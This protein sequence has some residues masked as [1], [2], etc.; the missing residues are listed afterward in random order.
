[1]RLA[2]VRDVAACP[3]STP[4]ASPHSTSLTKSRSFDAAIR[5]VLTRPEVL[6]TKTRAT[7]KTKSSQ[8]NVDNT[9]SI[10]IQFLRTY[11]NI[12][13]FLFRTVV[14]TPLDWDVSRTAS[15]RGV[16]RRLPRFHK[17]ARSKHQPT[18][19]PAACPVSFHHPSPHPISS[20]ATSPSPTHG[21][22]ALH[23]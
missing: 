9:D 20:Q 14:S 12:T 17:L 8:M 5:S 21:I 16:A 4:F 3:A 11:P 6:P 23:P 18:P 7:T 22:T 13:N 2:C 19:T 1:M 15:E 10:A